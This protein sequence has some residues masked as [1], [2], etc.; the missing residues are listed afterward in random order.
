M[1]T[2]SKA[3]APIVVIGAGIVGMA[4]ACYLQRAGYAVVVLD[5]N[6][7]GEGASFGNAGCLNGSSV[8][9]VSMPG[10]LSQVPRWLLDPEGPLA[11]RWRYLPALAPWLYRF[12]LAGRPDRV[13]EVAKALRTLLAS[14]IESYGPLAKDAGAEGLIHRRGH[15]FAY[16]SD[17]AYE[18]DG[19]AMQLRRDN[20]IE[21]DELSA[22]E[23]RQLEPHLSHDYIRARLIRENG[24]CE[25]PPRLV[26]S[27]AEMLV[28]NG[29]AI[30]REKAVDFV[31]EGT[32]VTGVRTE[33]GVQSAAGVV[34][35]AGAFSKPLAA[36]LGDRVPLDTERGYHVMV[37]D[38]EV[39]PHIP[40]NSVDG[41][42]VVTP[43][44]AG[45]CFA[46]TVEFAGLAAPPD[47]R[48]A[49]ILLKQG[50]AM[51]P[52]LAREIPEDR[53]SMWMG[54]RPSMPDSLPVI[55]PASRF[56]NAFYAFGHGHVGLVGGAMTGRV[57]A[58]LVA[59]QPPPI[60]IAP[61]SAGRF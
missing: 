52:G 15:L 46:G 18:K 20:G 21:I 28:R 37:R 61:F 3:A 43:M 38:P 33:T 60:D 48:R 8:V 22:D 2:N 34:I 10:M 39:A 35:A 23:L 47:W 36:K 27:F 1:A 40:T 50:Q 7:P 51:Y 11:I 19:A 53:L 26:R 49:R 45:L 44:E 17:A 54:F 55:G 12:A 41:K 30:R 16:R 9:P 29:G 56:G 14:S 13:R 31:V 4:S 25:N 58:A 42:F 57:I 24:H 5:P 59:R 6:P 32:R